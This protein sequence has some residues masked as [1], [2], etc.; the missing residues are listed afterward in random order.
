MG[1]R[2]LVGSHR[3]NFD[4]VSAHVVR[5]RFGVLL[6]EQVNLRCAFVTSK[7]KSNVDSGCSRSISRDSVRVLYAR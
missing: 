7:T 4:P 6:I 1:T 2:R 3:A 5:A